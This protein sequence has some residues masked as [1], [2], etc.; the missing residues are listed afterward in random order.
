[1]K[2]SATSALLNCWIS[3]QEFGIGL[4]N[5]QLALKLYFG[6]YLPFQRV[7][8]FQIGLCLDENKTFLK[9]ESRHIGWSG[10]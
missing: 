6:T 2:V 4:T 7:E 9:V 3:E 10:L 5:L 1:M 8:T